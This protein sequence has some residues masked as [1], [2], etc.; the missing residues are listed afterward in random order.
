M[1]HLIDKDA[2]I[3]EIEKLISNGQVK[4]QE[5]QKCNDDESYVAWSEHIA[6]CIKILSFLDTLEVNPYEQCIQYASVK[7]GIEAHAKTYSFNI[8]SLLF[9]QLTK[10]QQALWGK[11]IEQACISGGEYGVEIARDLR[12]K[13]NLEAKEVDLKKENLTWKDIRNLCIIFAEIDAEIEFCETDIKGETIGYYQEALKRLKAQK[14][15]L[16]DTGRKS[17]SL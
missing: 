3:A 1:K 4:L 16:Y 10:E 14:G 2:L 11:E 15:E 5:A 7:D 6:T 8:E 9:N 17:K 12:Y 13:E